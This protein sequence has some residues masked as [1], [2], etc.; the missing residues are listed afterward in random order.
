[1]S[2]EDPNFINEYLFMID[3]SRKDIIENLREIKSI[4]EAGALKEAEF[5]KLEFEFSGIK[6][7]TFA[8]HL[9]QPLIYVNSELIE[10][11]PIVLQTASERD[12]V[13]HLKEFCENNPGYFENK[14]MYLLR[15]MSRGRG[16][17]FFEA[18]NFYPDYIIWQL[19]EGKQYI[20]FVDPKGLRHSSEYDPKIEFYKTIKE[21]ESDLSK[22]EKDVVLNSFIISAS[23]YLELSGKW[24]MRRTDF[25]KRHVYFQQEDRAG[26]IAKILGKSLV[27]EPVKV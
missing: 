25:E 9:Y 11:K 14:E 7:L 16:I 26:Y 6:S 8:N 1:M 21:L 24:N 23:P 13:I 4:I 17:G 20:S 3:Q 12:F 10:V 5:K 19:H 2:E 22:Q 15:N 27:A 18:G